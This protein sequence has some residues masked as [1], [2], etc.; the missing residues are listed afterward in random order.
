[1]DW[2]TPDEADLQATESQKS[3]HTWVSGTHENPRWQEGSKSPPPE[4]S[5][6][7]SSLDRAQIAV[8]TADRS[9]HFPR[10]VRI[11]R[12]NEIRKLLEQGK[13]K[14][15][16]NLEMFFTVSEASVSRFGVI[17]PKYGRRIVDRNQLKRRL[18]EI[19]RRSVLPQL[20]SIG[21]KRDVLV[22]A[23]RSAYEASFADLEVEVNSALE[24]LFSKE[25]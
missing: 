11:R 2:A 9:E 8:D 17:V 10:S 16:K 3:Q 14:S 7:T 21:W 25:S 6:S 24:V 20:K 18:R 23:D 15:T 12:S 19:G 5:R 4:R 13:R 1:M 22:R